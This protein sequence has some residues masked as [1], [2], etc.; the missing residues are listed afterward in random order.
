M[1]SNLKKLFSTENESTEN[2][3]DENPNFITR[4]RRIRSMLYLLMEDRTQISVELNEDDTHS[5]AIREIQDQ[6]LLIDELNLRQAHVQMTA[7]TT[8]KVRA[9]HQAVHLI[10]ESEIVD[11]S[12]NG[13]LIKL[14]E[15]IYYPQR[16]SYFRVPLTSVASFS[17]RAGHSYSDLPL[18]GRIEDISYGGVSLAMTDPIYFKK[19]DILNPASLVLNEGEVAECSLTI[20]SVKNSPTTGMTRLGCEFQELDKTAR[21]LINQFIIYCERERAKSGLS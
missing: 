20:C 13:Y 21:R 4:P 10:F 2:S 9:K 15:K 18:T 17:F 6:C 1:F 16:R 14:P 19:G 5:T 7:G 3:Q 8:I 12:S 11:I